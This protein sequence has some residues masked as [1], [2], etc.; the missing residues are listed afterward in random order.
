MN[1]RKDLLWND[2]DEKLLL[3]FRLSK[4]RILELRENHLKTMP[5]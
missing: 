5:K 3:L 1:I 4:L 2:L